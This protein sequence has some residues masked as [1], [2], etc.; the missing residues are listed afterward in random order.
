[1]FWIET[2]S[3]HQCAGFFLDRA[4]QLELAVSRRSGGDRKPSLTSLAEKGWDSR[5]R[6]CGQEQSCQIPLS[7]RHSSIFAPVRPAPH[8]PA[9][10][11]GRFANRHSLMCCGL[12]FF[13]TSALSL[14]VNPSVFALDRR[15]Q[16]G[17]MNDKSPHLAELT[18]ARSVYLNLVKP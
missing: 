17:H 1:M 9:F 12:N 18:K 7:H 2:R 4:L 11:S 13:R 14:G 15:P 6:T 3:E 16:R 8:R 5:R 10:F